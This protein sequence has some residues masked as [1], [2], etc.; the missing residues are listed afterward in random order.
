MKNEDIK[1]LALSL[2]RAETEKEVVHILEKALLWSDSSAWKEFNGN[3]GNWSTIGNQQSSAD[4]AIV[5]KII[6][7][8]DAVLTR[9][10]LRS[11]IQPESLGA[12][13][14][15]SEAQKKYFGIYN[16]KLSSIDARVRS[17]LAE[18]IFLVATGKDDGY[19]NPSYAI[20][21]SGEGQIPEAFH[22]TFLSLTKGNK[23]K[24]QFVQGKF[25]MGGTG[26]FRFG[27]PEHNLQLIISKRDP[28]IKHG[29]KSDYWGVT[30]IRRIP[31]TGQMK[32][33]IFT[34]LA[35]ENKILSFTSTS[36][37]LLP[38]VDLQPY[39]K[40]LGH[41]TFVKI[42]EYKIGTGRLKSDATRHLHNRL[43]LLMPNIALPIKIADI[44]YKKSPIKTLSGLSV[45]LDDDKRENLEENFPSSGELTIK[46]EKMDYSIYAFKAGKRDTY[47]GKEG[48]IFTVNG[49]T[50]G[51]ISKN[52]FESKTVGMSYLS[53]SILVIVDCTKVDR[54]MHEDLFMNSRDRLVE[55][56]L[57]D[58]I[59][60]QFGDIIKNH[61]GLKTLREKRRREDIENKLQDSKP[62]ADILE[63]IIK[64]SPSLS[65]LFM[66]GVRIQNPF[67][68]TGVTEQGEFKGKNFPTY[69]T[70]TKEYPKEK[71][72]SC[73]INRKFRIQYE[74]D[75]NNDYFNRDKEPGELTLK[76]NNAPIEDYSLNLWNGL[77]TLTIGLHQDSKVGDILCFQTTVIDYTRVEAIASGFCVKVEE[78]QN[79][80]EG[81]DGERK[82]PYSKET[83][84]DRQKP[85]Y[86]D[87]PN[88]IEIRREKWDN[89]DFDEK[90][91]LKVVDAG[92]DAGYDFFIN[93][94]NVYLQMEIKG[95]TK[96][97]PRILEAR[98]KYGM[99]LLGISLLDFEER[100]KKDESKDTDGSTSIYENIL[101][102]SKAISPTLLPMISS[103]GDLE[104]DG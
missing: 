101:N 68:L 23:S 43:S 20:I 18:N 88:A 28:E 34:Y 6:N 51:S 85:S 95:S 16:G 37:P 98:F 60:E 48:I 57:K 2:A 24:I 44:R 4:A 104:M 84:K 45:R 1:K 8:V 26:V 65:S 71:P 21:D 81:Q 87:I 33:S 39:A 53:D 31:P 38:V 93:M 22:D 83:G 69:F 3:S 49:Q 70:L 76:I 30:V 90:S 54:R 86:L 89:H 17:Q 103:L 50:H 99:V 52:F 61:P 46:G 92:E 74:T 66:Q 14:S 67:N 91:A 19:I 15:I 100:K 40:P 79:K 9:E 72:K 94:D 73:P 63:N 64:K 41:G 82:K 56:I 42:Y 12:P 96:I 13:K 102:F 75:A 32:S 27:S 78:P 35:P 29:S 10:C 80:T 5:E 11:G 47:A 59:E 77:A 62:L 7:S 58:E 36:L 97:D 25:G 55:G